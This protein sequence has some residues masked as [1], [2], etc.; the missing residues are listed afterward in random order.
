MIVKNEED[1]L[2]D[3][4]KSVSGVA[5]EIVIVDTGSTDDTLNIARK[6]NAN[7]YN[8]EWIND[9]SAARN[10]ALSKT[11]CEWILYLDADER[12]SPESYNEIEKIKKDDI[13]AG[14]FCSVISFDEHNSKPNLI[15]YNR[16][17]RNSGDIYF[18]GKIHEQ[19]VHSLNK[20]GYQLL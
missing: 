15:R 12:L 8:F 17:F 19:I 5:D 4:L 13:K 1:Y 10:F 9:F 20:N 6:Y 14:Y 11:S 7:I 18:E 3:C 16:L 2:E